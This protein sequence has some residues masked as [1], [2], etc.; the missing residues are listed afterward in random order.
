MNTTEEDLLLIIIVIL[1]ETTV[2]LS[3]QLGL[4]LHLELLAALPKALDRVFEAGRGLCVPVYTL[5]VSRRGI[6]SWCIPHGALNELAHQFLHS[7][8]LL[9][10]LKKR[11]LR[12][13]T[14]DVCPRILVR[15]D[16][17]TKGCHDVF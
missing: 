9:E 6:E 15:P 12:E 2:A 10:A 3:H 11:L 16:K 4:Q 14:C 1:C 7:W 17:C 13:R 8:V 5:V